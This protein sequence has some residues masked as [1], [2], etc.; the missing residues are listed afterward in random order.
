MDGAFLRAEMHYPAPTETETP[1]PAAVAGP[2]LVLALRD[3]ELSFGGVRALKGVSLDVRPQRDP[4]GHRA[5]R[6]RQ[7]VAGQH[8]QRALPRR[9]GLA[10]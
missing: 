8:H 6:R 4:R 5:E 2:A 1:A 3:I 7:V 9:R 10:S